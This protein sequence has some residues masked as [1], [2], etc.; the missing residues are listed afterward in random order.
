MTMP[1]TTGSTTTG[2]SIVTRNQADRPKRP[3]P[4]TRI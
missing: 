4:M 2:D 1:R 3:H